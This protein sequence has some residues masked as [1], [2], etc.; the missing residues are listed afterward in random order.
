MRS[1]V[2]RILEPKGQEDALDTHRALLYLARSRK[3][4]VR[5]VTTN[6][7]AIFDKVIKNENMGISIY[8]APMLPLAKDSRWDGL[9]YLHGRLPQK[10]DYREL[11]HLVLTSGDFGL[12][13]LTERWAARFVTRLFSNY[14][15][16]FVGYSINDPVLRYMMDALAADRRVGE[17]VPTAYAFACYKDGHEEAERNEWRSKGV[18]PILY[19]DGNEH[20][21][22]HQTLKKWSEVY[23][24]GAQ[25]KEQIV[26]E[27]ALVAPS[28]SSQQNNFVSRLLWAITDRSGKPAQYFAEH[29]PVPPLEWLLDV[30]S[31]K[32]FC[33]SDLE[34]FGVASDKTHEKKTDFSVVCRPSYFPYAPWMSL[35]SPDDVD[36][37]LDQVM[38]QLCC[39]LVRH[40]GD[41]RLLV[42][43][44]NHG[45]RLNS[46]FEK[47]IND[48]LTR[49]F[50]LEHANDQKSLDELDEIR[51]NAPNAIPGNT[52]RKLWAILLSGRACMPTRDFGLVLYQWTDDLKRNGLCTPLRL[53]LREILAPK[54]RFEKPYDYDWLESD[55]NSKDSPERL[56]KE[57]RCEL[58]LTSKEIHSAIQKLGQ[59]EYWIKAL[60]LL[61]DEFQRLLLDAM[62][63]LVEIGQA[64]KRY[65]HSH[66]YMPSISP[67]WQNRNLQEWTILIEL[68]R[69]SWIE[70]LKG[71]IA[72]ARKIAIDWFSIPYPVFKRLALFAASYDDVISPDQW[73]EWLSSEGSWWLWS[74]TTGR[75]LMRL[76]VLQGKNLS[77]KNQHKLERLILQRPPREMFQ[78]DIERSDWEFLVKNDIWRRLAK[79]KETG[80]RFSKRTQKYYDK[81]VEENPDWRLKTNEHDEFSFWVSGTGDPDFEENRLVN[82]APQNREELVDWLKNYIVKIASTGRWQLHYSDTWPEVCENNL[83]ASGLALFDLSSSWSKLISRWNETINIWANEHLCKESW[84]HFAKLIQNMPDDFLL[85]MSP[86]IPRWLCAVAKSL[87]KHENIFW[88]LCERLLQMPLEDGMITNNLIDRAINHPVGRITEAML[89]LL[90]SYSHDNNELL[91]GKHRDIFTRICNN[92]EDR[93]RSGRLVLASQTILLFQLDSQWTTEN[94]FPLFGWENHTEAQST[95]TGFLR[96]PMIYWP[97]LIALKPLFLDTATHYDELG[98]AGRRYAQ[99]LTYVILGAAEEYSEDEISNAISKLPQEGLEVVIRALVEAL[100]AA[101]VEK[102]NYWDN[103]I[104][105]FWQKYWPKDKKYHSKSISESLVVLCVAADTRFPDAFSSVKDWLQPIE[106]WHTASIIKNSGLCEKYP[107]E[108]LLLLDL[109]CDKNSYAGEDLLNVLERIAQ[110]K[111]ELS[112]DNKYQKLLEL[113]KQ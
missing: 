53:R 55:E 31:K 34:R 78:P 51:S 73:V 76:F 18:E 84:Q 25:G 85:A 40:L 52:I 82:I 112:Q 97:L 81:I 10:G 36:V 32:Y 58:S 13:Y 64:D 65:D 99:F 28:E 17:S 87:D 49:F 4:I 38:L 39:W 91:Q 57:V 27:C 92:N 86:S 15:V 95:W 77:Q 24:N 44:S 56:E 111:H 101:E 61:I 60:P 96:R 88:D 104:S 42:W 83:H 107:E 29:N 9:V 50:Q 6:F 14:T 102:E 79:L 109:T 103:K 5:L 108:V 113:T 71:D 20:S 1:V 16:C 66:T 68:L 41:P 67:H 94:L 12:A 72:R 21:A 69:D 100:K 93:C 45:G 90:F 54:V 8:T 105:P 30:F 48:E 37:Q 35:V 46:Y 19:K 106:I 22:L 23:R 3:G 7:D 110:A 74:S 33:Q 11:K 63:L 43:I 47:L 89:N 2:P 98:Y 26:R 59:N 70:V 75:E 62:D 80:I